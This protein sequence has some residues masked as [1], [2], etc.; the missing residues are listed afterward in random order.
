LKNYVPLKQESVTDIQGAGIDGY[1]SVEQCME[2]L[3]PNKGISLR[4]FRELQARGR[5]PYLK[6]GRRTLF[7]PAEVRAALE[8]NFKRAAAAV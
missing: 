3:F 4:T 2:L 8:K 1:V 7:N 6:L 5:I